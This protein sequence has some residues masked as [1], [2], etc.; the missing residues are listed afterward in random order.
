MV[1]L[2]GHSPCLLALR[3]KAVRDASSGQSSALLDPCSYG[4]ESLEPLKHLKLQVA[5]SLNPLYGRE[6]LE[7]YNDANQFSGA[8]ARA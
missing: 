2:R 7:H 3:V 1:C 8:T 5:A 6:S 4:R